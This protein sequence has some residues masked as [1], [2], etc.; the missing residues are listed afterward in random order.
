MQHFSADAETDL[1]HS[2]VHP[3]IQQP[4]LPV[5]PR[6]HP[7]TYIGSKHLRARN[8]ISLY[9]LVFIFWGEKSTAITKESELLGVKSLCVNNNQEPKSIQLPGCMAV[10]FLFVL[11]KAEIKII[12]N[13]GCTLKETTPSKGSR[14]E[15]GDRVIICVDVYPRALSLEVRHNFLLPSIKNRPCQ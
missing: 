2:S 3:S 15:N 10:S 5:L 4:T 12:F 11:H 9:R 14:G 7:C 1:F 6:L 13:C 8:S